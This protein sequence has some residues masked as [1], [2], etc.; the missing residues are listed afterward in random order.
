MEDLRGL[1]SLFSNY[2][3]PEEVDVDDDVI[4]SG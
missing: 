2:N 1:S 4:I 3:P